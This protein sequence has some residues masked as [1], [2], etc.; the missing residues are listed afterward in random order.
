MPGHRYVEDI[1][2]V[3]MLAVKRSAGATPEVNLREC[4][5]CMPLASMNKASRETQRRC[6][7]KSKTGVS[8]APQKDLCPPNFFLKKNCLLC[9]HHCMD[10]RI[11]LLSLFML[12]TI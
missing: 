5:T 4:V 7:Q 12:L 2:S 10:K 3:A 1:G 8:V 6:H 9:C 11:L